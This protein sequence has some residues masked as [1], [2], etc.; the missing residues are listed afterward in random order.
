[1]ISITSTTYTVTEW[2][3]KRNF[4]KTENGISIPWQYNHANLIFQNSKVWVVKSFYKSLG[5]FLS[6]IQK[7][8]TSSDS[9]Q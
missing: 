2:S 5:E 9:E 6:T 8:W 4:I 7:T 1:M 3:H